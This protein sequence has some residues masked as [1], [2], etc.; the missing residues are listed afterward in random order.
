MFNNAMSL[1][2]AILMIVSARAADPVFP[3][4]FSTSFDLVNV[5]Q[6]VTVVGSVAI[7]AS[8]AGKEKI[9]MSYFSP[10]GNYT[11]LI[12]NDDLHLYMFAP[13]GPSQFRG[14]PDCNEALRC[15]ATA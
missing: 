9:M 11:T 1:F 10:S 15:T 12:R 14:T 8:I 7:D 4:S 3:K 2:L 5:P 6:D 13:D